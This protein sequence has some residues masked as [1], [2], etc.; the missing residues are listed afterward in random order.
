MNNEKYNEEVFQCVCGKQFK[1]N[2]S[3]AAHKSQCKMY[4]ESLRRKKDSR[5][6]PNGMFKCE[7]PDCGKEHDGSYASGR[8]CCEKCKRHYVSKIGA[9]TLIKDGRKHRPKNFKT[10]TSPYGTWKCDICGFIAKTRRELVLHKKEL[11]HKNPSAPDLYKGKT[12]SEEHREKIRQSIIIAVKEGRCTGHAKTTE[13]EELRKKRI[14]E[15]ALK[16]TTPRSTK[17]TE[18]YNCKDG[19]IVNLDSSYERIVAKI[20]DDNNIKWI[21]P[22]PLVWYSDDCK[23]HHYFPDF[24]LVDFDVYLDPKNDYCFKVQAEKIKC[25]QKQYNNV[26]FLRKTDL[27]IEFINS[28]INK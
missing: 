19:D 2:K 17:R 16:R 28:C 11:N 4:L 8:F 6:L 23:K 21:R 3:L 10:S 22:K 26:K 7:N 13:K 24:Y 15:A 25:V 27:T 1:T 12:L 5:R 18:P 20:L 9:Q 14:S